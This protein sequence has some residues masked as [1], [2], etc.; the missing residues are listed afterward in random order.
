MIRIKKKIK[1]SSILLVLIC[2]GFL[3]CQKRSSSLEY[4]WITI[5]QDYAPSNFIEEF[6]KNDSENRGLLPVYI[7]NY[8]Q[9]KE[10]LRRF[11]GTL[12]AKPN[13]AALKMTFPGLEDWLLL[14][15][16][17]ENEKKQEVLR[18]ILYVQ[19]EGKWKV[20]DS[21]RLLE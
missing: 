6:I 20:G 21:G 1:F 12:L 7:K 18:T 10:V 2:S 13:E 15:L 9:D 16:R 19:T 8:D 4:E 14:D 11:R 17:Y 3:G 5:D